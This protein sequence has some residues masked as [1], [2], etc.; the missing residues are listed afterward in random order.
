MARARLHVERAAPLALAAAVAEQ[1]RIVR[2]G[3][4]LS[5]D[6][7]NPRDLRQIRAALRSWWQGWHR[8]P[9]APPGALDLTAATAALSPYGEVVHAGTGTWDGS[10]LGRVAGRLARAARVTGR[11]PRTEVEIRR[12]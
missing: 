5:L 11:G 9:L 4:A 12:R 10:A 6:A 1:A 7:P 8:P 3:G 2:S